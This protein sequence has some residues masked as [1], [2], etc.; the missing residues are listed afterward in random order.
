MA[1]RPSNVQPQPTQDLSNLVEMWRKRL[2]NEWDDQDVWQNLLV[3]RLVIFERIATM[4][5]KTQHDLRLQFV[6]TEMAWTH[7]Q[8]ATTARIH[9]L[10]HLTERHLLQAQK[11]PGLQQAESFVC[12]RE[13]VRVAQELSPDNFKEQLDAIDAINLQIFDAPQVGG[14]HFIFSLS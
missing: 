13:S 14:F 7:N 10:Q 6:S 1:L 11:I 5:V 4:N 2:P 9:K 12:A 3:W 8:L